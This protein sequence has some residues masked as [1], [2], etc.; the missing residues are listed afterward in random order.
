[1]LTFVMTAVCPE[2]Q[3]AHAASNACLASNDRRARARPSI[4]AT[5]LLG[6]AGLAWAE[7]GPLL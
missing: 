2:R 6:L 4:A 3:N 1:M 7:R 5:L